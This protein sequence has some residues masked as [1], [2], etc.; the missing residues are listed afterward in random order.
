MQ[1]PHG[2]LVACAPSGALAQFKCSFHHEDI[3]LLFLPLLITFFSEVSFHLI[4]IPGHNSS[5]G[6]HPRFFTMAY[7]A[8][9]SLLPSLPLAPFTT[10]LLSYT[11]LAS[12]STQLSCVLMGG[13]PSPSSFFVCLLSFCCWDAFLPLGSLQDVRS[14]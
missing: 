12:C 1:L 9:H 4:S 7:K 5:C 14:G 13:P 11:P 3:P 8:L 6:V 10:Q 2:G